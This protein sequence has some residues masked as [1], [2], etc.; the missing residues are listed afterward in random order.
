MI[1]N[2]LIGVLL[3]TLASIISNLGL[4]L[5]KLNHTLNEQR[6]RVA[7]REERR[8]NAATASHPVSRQASGNEYGTIG[9]KIIAESTSTAALPASSGLTRSQRFVNALFPNSEPDQQHTTGETAATNKT[10]GMEET[11]TINKQ[12]NENGTT[13]TQHL[14]PAQQANL[15]AYE[16]LNRVDY[17]RQT[18]WRAGLGLVTAGS[19]L[20]FIALI[21]AP[22][23]L[24]A[25]LG[26]LTLVSNTFLAP[27]LLGETIRLRD[28]LATAAIVAGSILAVVFADHGDAMYDTIQLFQFF[29][30]KQFGL[31]AL[32]ITLAVCG[33]EAAKR[34]LTQ[35]RLMQPRLYTSSSYSHL[36]RF[37]YASLAG[38]I[39]AQ[40]V[41]FA[42]CAGQLLV[43]WL[44]G[45]NIFSYI[46][47]YVLILGLVLSIFFQ[48]SL[49]N[50]GL[51]LFEALYIVPVFQS[52]WILVSVTGGMIVFEEYRNV[53]DDPSSGI[54]FPFGVIITIGGVWILSQRGGPNSP[55][56][57]TPRST[58][59]QR[60][61]THY[62]KPHPS[63]VPTGSVASAVAPFHSIAPPPTLHFDS[64]QN[65]D[66]LAVDLES[67]CE[68]PLFSY[69]SPAPPISFIAGPF[70]DTH[71]AAQA[72]AQAASLS[73][74]DDIPSTYLLPVSLVDEVRIESEVV[75]NERTRLVRGTPVTIQDSIDVE[76]IVEEPNMTSQPP[77]A[78]SSKTK[79]TKSKSKKSQR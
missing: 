19:I 26:S 41:L 34:F 11:K 69:T 18:M 23:S 51:K 72:Q 28:L 49:L 74:H 37:T 76:D 17:S 61:Y 53:F 71:Y 77:H 15:E 57:P 42:K 79:Q 70:F 33:L 39:G 14:T 24:I 5:Q 43:N 8:R 58:P 38:I 29:E 2:W 20:D 44:S 48:I 67:G 25:P 1:P 52:F 31:Y 64:F 59:Q 62:G 22:Q 35:M 30:T 45:S 47:T 4:N 50:S 32:V 75:I 66:D 6:I 16:Q 63:T 36:H 73:A 12:N 9:T 40:S 21:F 56:D 3:A 10:D 60:N 7:L 46:Q 55:S 68:D 13:T 27:I 54:L 78:T 65:S